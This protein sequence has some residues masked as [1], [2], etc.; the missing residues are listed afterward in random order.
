MLNEQGKLCYVT[1]NSFMYNSSAA[2][3]QN[4]SKRESLYKIKNFGS[5]NFSRCQHIQP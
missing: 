3:F 1:P 4:I 5:E 2:V